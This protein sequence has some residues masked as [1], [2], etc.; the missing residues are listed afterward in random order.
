M[1]PQPRT[2][3]T[4]L[5]PNQLHILIAEKL[6][7]RTNRI[8]PAAHASHHRPRQLPNLAQKLPP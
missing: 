4:S 8:R 2:S 3:P 6:I 5:H 7:E 1:I